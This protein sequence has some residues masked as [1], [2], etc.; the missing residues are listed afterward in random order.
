[1]R[2]M[3]KR[4][5]MILMKY[6]AANGFAALDERKRIGAPI[7]VQCED[8]LYLDEA[9]EVSEAFARR[10]ADHELAVVSGTETETLVE[11]EPDK[12]PVEVSARMVW[13]LVE[14]EA[15]YERYK[16]KSPE[17]A[18]AILEMLL[19]PEAT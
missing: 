16:P 3:V 4:Q 6:A 9:F 15:G 7:T 19:F 13:P 11:I 12:G 17:A 8:R 10:V 5:R 14:R 18:A 1:M 2:F